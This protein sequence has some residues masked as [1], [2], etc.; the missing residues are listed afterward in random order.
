MEA[1]GLRRDIGNLARLLV[2]HQ[3]EAFCRVV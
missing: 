3:S 1:Y 2:S